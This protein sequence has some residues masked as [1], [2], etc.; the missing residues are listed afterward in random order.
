MVRMFFLQETVTPE[1]KTLGPGAEVLR[2]ANLGRKKLLEINF[3]WLPDAYQKS[4]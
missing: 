4:M 3:G 2:I 1:I